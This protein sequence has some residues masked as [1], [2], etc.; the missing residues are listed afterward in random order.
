MN[1]KRFIIFIFFNLIVFT[2]IYVALFYYQL[3]ANVKSESWIDPMY[4]IKDK[5]ALDIGNKNKIIIISG[6]N[7]LFGIN[8]EL[9]STITN[10]PVLNLAVHAGLDID[11]L[12]YKINKYIQPNDI[13]VMPLEYV[14]YTSNGY[15]DWFMNNIL[16]W[17][18]D[19][20]NSLNIFD[21]IKFI[22]NLNVDRL[23]LGL[24]HKL[25]NEIYKPTENVV[26]D[27]TKILNSYGE[28]WRGYNYKSSNLDGDINADEIKVEFPLGEYFQSN[29]TVSDHFLIVYNK[30]D[31]LIKNNN[32]KLILTHPIT[33]NN[34][35]YNLNNKEHQKRINDFS[36]IL[37][38]NNVSISCNPSLFHINEIYS[39]NTN[40]HAN[41]YG[42]LIRSENLGYCI[43]ELIKNPNFN[44]SYEEAI[45]LTNKL[46]QKYNNYV[47]KQNYFKRLEDLNKLKKALEKYYSDNGEYPLSKGFDG[48][49][50]NWGY[51]GNDWIKGL[52][53]KYINELPIDPRNTKDAS[54]QYLYKSNGKDYKLIS[55]SPEDCQS[56]ERRNKNFID[57]S[58]KCGAYGF[59]TDGAKNW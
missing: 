35:K 24:K 18:N 36:F 59:W 50:T 32:A 12:Y 33:F 51:S 25:N 54:L 31:K 34:S 20:F 8:T 29:I 4:Q 41:K 43:N 17:G 27:L 52:S 21:K 39:F 13:V 40:Y 6:S 19:Y 46:E 49:Y 10:K 11:Y 42:A 38:A 22:F 28:K 57:P 47:K 16:V 55:H 58:R 44:L 3:G 9:I 7:S 48:I 15:S 2:I 23:S 5:K 14:Y 37:S 1:K 30:I 56:V 26:V 53:P 45:N